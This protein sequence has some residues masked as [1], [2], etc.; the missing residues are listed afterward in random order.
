MSL[1]MN[2]GETI[3]KITKARLKTI[4]LEELQNVMKESADFQKVPEEIKTIIRNWEDAKL[5]SGSLTMDPTDKEI[6]IMQNQ[7]GQEKYEVS[8]SDRN[9]IVFRDY[10]TNAE[11]IWLYNRME[12]IIN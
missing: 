11:Y 9:S 5:N 10:E 7:A 8:K 6:Q 12:W 2:I 3:M 1:V 4:I